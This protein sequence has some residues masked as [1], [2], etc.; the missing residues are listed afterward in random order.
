MSQE[1]ILLLQAKMQEQEAL[2]T[3]LLNFRAELVLQ[4]QT[5]LQERDAALAQNDVS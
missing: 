2:L 1:T 3:S 4:Q 5:V